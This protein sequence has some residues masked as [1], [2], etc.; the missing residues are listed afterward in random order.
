MGDHLT[1]LRQLLNDYDIKHCL[2]LGWSLGGILAMELA[3]A[4][5]ERVS[6]LILVAT[7]ARPRGS[8]PP[9]T[10]QD[11]LFTGVASLINRAVPSWRWNIDTFGR[12]S[13]Y[14]YLIQQ[15]TAHAYRRFADEALPAYLQ[16]SRQ[17]SQALDHA[18]K[19]GYNRLPDIAQIQV[20]CLMLCAEG[21]RH[22][23]AASSMETARQLPDCQLQTYPNA[24]HL[25]PWEI[26]DQ[27]LT[28]CDRWLAA[29]S[30]SSAF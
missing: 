14:R 12:R 21:D 20:P 1:D 17:A 28:D 30:P 8:H 27:V 9:I 5:P 7:A 15:H 29:R 6:G 16:T 2:V 23:T 4:E 13:L 25:F 3:L 11:N 24:A 26:P 19:A 22:I 18:L 10:W